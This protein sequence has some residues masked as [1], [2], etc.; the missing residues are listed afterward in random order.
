M[1]DEQD[2]TE[3][4]SVAQAMATATSLHREG[5]LDVAEKIYRRVLE[6]V[7]EYPDAMHFLGVLLHQRGRTDEALEMIRTSISMAPATADWHN[8]L[9]NVLLEKG[10]AQEA[11]EVY[12]RALELDPDLASAQLNMGNLLFRS[13]EVRRAVEHYNHALRLTPD[14]YNAR[15]ML[16]ISFS[17]LGHTEAAAEVYRRWLEDEP[18]NPVARHLYAAC[19]GEDMPDRAADE[20]VEHLFDPFAEYF[21]EKLERLDYRAPELVGEA[22]A[23]EFPNASGNLVCLDD[24]AAQQQRD[25]QSAT[26]R[27]RVLPP[28][29]RT[30]P[31]AF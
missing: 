14:N 20:L 22:V 2:G 10:E 19:S 5:Q 12:G 23:R 18:T 26:H 7:P 8:N 25:E 21:D 13:G 4:V 27:A 28:S 3:E 17:T 30:T 1:A 9:G 16:G 29:N 6:A 24:K 15:R 31:L 11:R